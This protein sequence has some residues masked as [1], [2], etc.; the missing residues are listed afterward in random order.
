MVKGVQ[1]GD[2]Q[3]MPNSTMQKEELMLPKGREKNFL[4]ICVPSPVLSV[5][6]MQRAL[7]GPSPGDMKRESEMMGSETA[8]ARGHAWQSEETLGGRSGMGRGAGV[9]SHSGDGQF[10]T[11]TRTSWS[12]RYKAG[13]GLGGGPACPPA[14]E[15]AARR[16]HL[17]CL[18]DGSQDGPRRGV[19]E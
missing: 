12:L 13:R 14:P 10:H 6:T 4:I 8:S 17:P 16:T 15:G 9:S 1:V 18:T 3:Q 2:T 11:A 19:K 7:W 5:H